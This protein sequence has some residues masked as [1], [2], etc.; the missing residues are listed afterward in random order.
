MMQKITKREKILLFSALLLVI[1]YVVVQFVIF[2][3][4]SRYTDA[5]ADLQTLEDQRFSVEMDIANL[6]LIRSSN[7]AAKER[8]SQVREAYPELVP[9]ED[10]DVLMTN[11]ITRHNLSPTLLNIVRPNVPAAIGEPEFFA[12]VTVTMNLIG[13]LDSLQNLVDEVYNKNFMRI[14][15]LSYSISTVSPAQ[16]THSVTFELMYVIS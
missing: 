9:N 7:E 5:A 14:T 8:L 15:N 11:L 4:Y 2:P 6:P 13:S 1:F 16:S 10:I 12:V 3:L